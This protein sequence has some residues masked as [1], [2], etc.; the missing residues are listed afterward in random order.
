MMVHM[1]VK[2]VIGKTKNKVRQGLVLSY[3]LD[4]LAS[5]GIGI[6]ALYF[7]QEF[8]LDETELNLNPE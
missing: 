4:R 3:M 1:N 5:V 7:T 6:K 8:L 2:D